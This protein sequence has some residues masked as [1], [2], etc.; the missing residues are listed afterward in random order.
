MNK[1]RQIKQ[2]LKDYL[3]FGEKYEQRKN[4]DRMKNIE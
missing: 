2:K 1:N 4:I 3:T